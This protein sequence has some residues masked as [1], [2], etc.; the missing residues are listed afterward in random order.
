[1][2]KKYPP[3]GRRKN[4]NIEMMTLEGWGGWVVRGNDDAIITL[5]G[6]GGWV[7]RK[8]PKT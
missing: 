8:S 5:E 4:W 7:G 3:E 1:M 6:W 2:M